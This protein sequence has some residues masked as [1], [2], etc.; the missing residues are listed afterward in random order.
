MMV[1]HGERCTLICCDSDFA[2]D[3][4]FLF[5]KMTDYYGKGNELIFEGEGEIILK[6]Q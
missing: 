4:V 2:K 6:H 3:L 5:P 1:P